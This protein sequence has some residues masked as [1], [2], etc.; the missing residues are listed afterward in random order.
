MKLAEALILRKDMQ[1]R[2]SVLEDRLYASARVQ[3][4]DKPIEDPQALLKELDNLTIELA[5][6]IARINHTNSQTLAD[7]ESLTVLLARRDMLQE[8]VRILR[9]FSRAAGDIAN[10]QMLSEIRIMSTV[11]VSSLR[12]HEDAVAKSLRELDM[13]LQS[14]NWQTELASD[15]VSR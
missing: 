10:R 1:G 5:A 14:L 13:K 6:L 2:L 7:G 15:S 9:G 3:E 8:K 4:G 11:D 12:K